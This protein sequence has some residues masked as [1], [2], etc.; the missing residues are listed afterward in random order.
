VIPEPKAGFITFTEVLPPGDHAGYNAWHQ[1]DHMPEQFQ[2]AGVVFGQRW[3][4]A[5]ECQAAQVV[6][7]DPLP[8]FHYLTLYLMVE[9][10]AQTL[11][12]FAAVRE[13]VT[14]LGRFYR[15]RRAPLSGAWRYLGAEVAPRVLVGAGALPHR[16]NR[17][18]YV[19]VEEPLDSTAFDD[20]ARWIHTSHLPDVVGV[21]GVAGVLSFG[22]RLW[23]FD[24]GAPDS[25]RISVMFL[26]GDPIET[27]ESLGALTRKRWEGAPVRPRLAAPCLTISPWEWDWFDRAEG[28][29]DG[30]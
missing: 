23:A 13:Q 6:T 30:S 11:D 8:A 14:E 12:E 20:Y 15:H 2:I 25:L 3:V 21:P 4:F 26:D 27:A 29:T 22:H 7:A 10:L 28:S 17:G 5:P 24:P 16:P 9:P 1:L 18:I 19:T